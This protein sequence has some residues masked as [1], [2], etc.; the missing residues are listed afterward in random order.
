M[1]ASRLLLLVA[2][3]L[4]ACSSDEPGG[5]GSSSGCADAMDCD[6][7][8]ACRDR[9]CVTL[10]S[11]RSECQPGEDCTASGIC[12]TPL[13]GPLPVIDGVSGNDA[14]SS[15]K[16]YDG[17]VI[18]G[19][20]LA[21]AEFTLVAA[22]GTA[23]LVARRQ[24]DLEAEVILPIDVRSGAYELVVTNASGS[25][26]Q[27]ITLELPE[28]T[29]DTILARLNAAAGEV[30][31][32]RLPVGSGAT[33][34]AA[35]DHLHDDAYYPR[36]EA[37]SVFARKDEI[38]ATGGG[39]NFITNPHFLLGASG[40]EGWAVAA[41]GLMTAAGSAPAGPTAFANTTEDVEAA[42]AWDTYVP[43]S[44][45]RA[46][47]LEVLAISPG[48]DGRL[49]LRLELLDA[50]G[51]LLDTVEATSTLDDTW[52]R[53]RVGFGAPW[54]DAAPAGT[55]AAR[56]T[57]LVAQNPS[58]GSVQVQDVAFLPAATWRAG[59]GVLST[60]HRVQVGSVALAGDE[61]M[62]VE[63]NARV[64]GQ[65][66]VGTDLYVAGG[67]AVTGNLGVTGNGAVAGTFS[68]TSDLGVG[69]TLSLPGLTVTDR[70]FYS[71]QR[72]QI[73]GGEY[74]YVL[75]QNGLVVSDAF[76][77]SGD[78]L[79]TGN[80]TVSGTVSPAGG[81]DGAKLFYKTGNTGANSCDAFCE[82]TSGG[83]RFG[84]CVLA[85]GVGTT[86]GDKYGC[87]NAAGVDLGCLCLE[88]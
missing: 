19:S 5:S 49:G 1:R 53:Y 59:A 56:L 39:D 23:T 84:V 75:N 85:V 18:V 73:D 31:I 55:V 70:T 67:A 13:N 79:V 25:D 60:S 33:E 7:G 3:V 29:G 86:Y 65:A 8:Q 20:S 80:A 6:G 22:T 54:P 62:I 42:L 35:G 34:V 21:S 72:I 9:V 58:G 28:L 46:Y 47:E 68:V 64:T 66:R 44:P 36:A 61:R 69:G 74:L 17:L 38:A 77:G 82:D 81:L 87:A 88:P 51:G 12:A 63:G 10:C 45:G 24:T 15:G 78:L 43:V 37:D 32:N 16:V 2:V 57:V 14:T 83:G 27:P 71:A 30:S 40:L 26:T 52:K 50:A 11:S 48:A 4:G 41:G 76:G